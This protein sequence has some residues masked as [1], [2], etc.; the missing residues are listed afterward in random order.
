MLCSFNS[1]DDIVRN[2][3]KALAKDTVWVN[4]SWTGTTSKKSFQSYLAN[5]HRMILDVSQET[6]NKVDASEKF[7]DSKIKSNLRHAPERLIRSTASS[8]SKK[9]KDK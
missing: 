4:V 5:I 7:I 2:L 6:F 9:N 8:S 1:K 3:L